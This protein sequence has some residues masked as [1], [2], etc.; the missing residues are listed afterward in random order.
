MKFKTLFL[1]GFLIMLSSNH[2]AQI[3]DTELGRGSFSRSG[4]YDFS[5]PG[6]I[7]IKVAVWGYV[8]RPGKYVVP[9]Y[10][11]VSDLLSFAGGPSRDSELDDLRIYRTLENGTEEMIKFN[12]NDIMWENNLNTKIRFTPKLQAS[13]ILV[14]P[15]SPKLFW[16]DW[17]NIGLQIFSI[18]LSI[19]SLLLAINYYN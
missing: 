13:D 2:F 12:Y 6:T 5:D 1:V 7:N 18:T 16:T 15:G 19:V 8:S 11:T 14:I 3:T 4:L 17:F 9:D 10:T